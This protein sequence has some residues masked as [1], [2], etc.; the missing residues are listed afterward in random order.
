MADEE[1][2]K[3]KEEAKEDSNHAKEVK[4]AKVKVEVKQEGGGDKKDDGKVLFSA[5]QFTD[6][7]GR[8][9]EKW[10]VVVA[11]PLHLILDHG[12]VQT[13][14]D[15]DAWGPKA[16]VIAIACDSDSKDVIKFPKAQSLITG[17]MLVDSVLWDAALRSWLA[18]K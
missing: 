5:S 9:Y 7:C 8:L 16:D 4:D 12:F 15:T 6:V 3:V 13:E 17:P 14:K 1:K 10:K 18:V 11:L 2:I